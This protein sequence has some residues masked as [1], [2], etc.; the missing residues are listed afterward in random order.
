MAS[1][2]GATDDV[3]NFD[4]DGHWNLETNEGPA[5]HA[6]LSVR[7]IVLTGPL[8]V[9]FLDVSAA[10]SYPK[11]NIIIMSATFPGTGGGHQSA[12]RSVQPGPSKK[13][14]SAGNINQTLTYPLLESNFDV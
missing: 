1:T 5:A 9:E 3:M 13:V 12:R 4:T 11:N 6:P 8:R 10:D 2:S 7:G 14:E